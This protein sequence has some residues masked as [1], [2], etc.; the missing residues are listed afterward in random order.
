MTARQYP[1]GRRP[2]QWQLFITAGRDATR[3]LFH[4]EGEDRRELLGL[5][6]EARHRDRRCAI[7]FV[8]P[9]G[10]REPYD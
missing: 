3:L 2:I 9:G 8:T 1:R 4:A 10:E 5:A 6:S 7:W